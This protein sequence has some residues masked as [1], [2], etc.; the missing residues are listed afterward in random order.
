MTDVIL[1]IGLHKTG[2]TY[3][4]R[5]LFPEL[6]GLVSL[7]SAFRFRDLAAAAARSNRILISDE[8]LCGLPFRSQRSWL[9]EFRA[10]VRGLAGLFPRAHVI[11]GVRRQDGMLLSLYK[12]YLHEGGTEP[13]E[14][15]FD[16]RANRGLLRWQDLEWQ[17]RIGL[18]KNVFGAPPFIYTQEEI[19]NSPSHFVNDLT[20]F[21]GL[22]AVTIETVPQHRNVG[23]NALQARLLRFMNRADRQF[24]RLPG[25]P[26]LNNRVLRKIKLHPRALCQHRLA[27]ISRRPLA[28]PEACARFVACHYQEDWEAALSSMRESRPTTGARSQRFQVL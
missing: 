1:H 25:T 14:R 13:I 23:V 8:A 27:W 9:D 20:R 17:P 28:L 7:V 2:T 4:Q 22:P 10:T 24:R 11:I 18:L 16:V 19:L 15:F 6:P 3:L 21:V 26:T 5:V 12:Q